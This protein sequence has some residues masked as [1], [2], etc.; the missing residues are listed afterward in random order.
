M[1]HFA[2]IHADTFTEVDENSIPTGILQKV[3]NSCMDFRNRQRI[4]ERI[5]EAEGNGYDHNYV[6]KDFDGSLKPG[7]EA[8]D[9]TTG[10]KLEVLTTEPG[11]QFYTANYLDGSIS[12]GD[13]VFSKRMG[14]CFETQH[15]P[16]TPN[17]PG[18]PTTLLNPDNEFK[19]TTIYKFS[20]T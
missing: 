16:D 2:V 4:G 9:E 20:T 8:S 14:F 12:R 10:I 19:S 1:N 3:K 17:Q 18:F 13:V 15:F 7:A 11:V 6:V 5:D